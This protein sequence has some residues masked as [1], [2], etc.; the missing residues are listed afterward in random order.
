LKCFGVEVNE[1][2]AAVARHRGIR[3][4]SEKQLRAGELRDC[5]AIL[6]T[7]VYEHLPRP[8]ELVGM[9]AALLRPGGWLALVTGCADAIRT[10]DYIGEFWYFR[11]PGHLQMLSER[12]VAWLAA[13]LG[14]RLDVLHRVPRVEDWP[15]CCGLL[16][17]STAPN[18]GLA[19]RR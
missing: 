9:L 2:A 19:P 4:L 1:E 3:I 6:L 12:H 11:L 14:L 10:R 13:G 5:A 7:D 16:R 15:R 17:S 18:N 8:M